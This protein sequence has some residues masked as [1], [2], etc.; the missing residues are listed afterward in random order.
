MKNQEIARILYDIADCLEMQG[1]DFKPNAYRRAAQQIERLSGDIEAYHKSGKLQD[2]PGVGEAISKKISEFLE[3]GR[4]K[5]YDELKNEVTPGLAALIDIP[6]LGPKKVKV[7]NQQLGIKDVDDLKKAAASH[8]IRE[9]AGFGEKSEQDIIAGIN[10]YSSGQERMLLGDALPLAQK[11]E[12]A[13]RPL[14]S[15]LCISGSIRRRKET[16]G[17]IDIL[18]VANTKI[19]DFFT[20]MPQVTRVLA[21]GGTKSSV[22]LGKLQVDL[23]LVRKESFG[24]AQQYFTGSKE[25]NIVLRELAIKKGLKLSEY[26]LFKGKK[27]IAGASEEG[28]YN[29]LGMQFIPPELRESSGEIDAALK[30]KLPMLVSSVKGDLQMHTRHSDGTATIAGMAAAA[31]ALGYEYICISDHSKSERIANGL[32][33]EALIKEI[34]EIRQLEKKAGIRIFAGCEVDIKQD[35]SL[36]YDD[37]ILKQLDIVIAA[38]HSGFKS[39]REDMT[40]RICKALENEY[41]DFLAHPTGRLI[42]RRPG[43]DVDLGKV[44]DAAL[45]NNVYLEINASPHRLDLSDVNARSAVEHKLKLMINTDAHSPDELL[46][47]QYGIATARRAWCTNKDIVNT[48]PLKQLVKQFKRLR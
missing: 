46:N 9:L 41:V 7:L 5:Y 15:Q 14:A 37:K 36:D 29:K 32:S 13:L 20:T 48:L 18:V 38:V 3:T 22:L 25:H 6:G 44:F 21:K 35:G 17:D 12:S 40:R 8:K 33:E 28:V 16:I 23:R 1:I 31:K 42:N 45:K 27:Q 34:G 19:M 47:M 39:S 43:Y 2:I 10:I 26:G 30:N 24:A 4:L 11:L